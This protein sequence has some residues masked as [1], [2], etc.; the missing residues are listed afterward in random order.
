M[1]LTELKI[2]L[3]GRVPADA[4]AEYR[5]NWYEAVDRFFQAAQ[6]DEASL[7]ELLNPLPVKARYVGPGPWLDAIRDSYRA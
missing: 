4:N 6:S 2:A 1:T 3:H 7:D 5:K